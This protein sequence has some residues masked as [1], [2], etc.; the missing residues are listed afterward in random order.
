MKC[1]GHADF[2]AMRPYIEVADETTARELAKWDLQTK[3]L[4]ISILLEKVSEE[5]LDKVLKLLRA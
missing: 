2:R 3:K 1:T 5:K 4:E